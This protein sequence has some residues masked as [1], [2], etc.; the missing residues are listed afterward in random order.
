MVTG[1]KIY[2]RTTRNKVVKRSGKDDEAEEFN[3]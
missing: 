1:K 3:M 2:S